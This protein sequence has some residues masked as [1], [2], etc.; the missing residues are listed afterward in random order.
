MSPEPPFAERARQRARQGDLPGAEAL[1]REGLRSDPAD[2]ELKG[3]LADVLD[4]QG[5][6]AEALTLVWEAPEMVR[7]RTALLARAGRSA[8]AAAALEEVLAQDPSAAWAHVQLGRLL[9]D[10]DRAAANA[11]FRKAVALDPE[12]LGARVALAYSLHSTRA[13][14]EGANLQAAAELVVPIVERLP[15][16][17]SA[18]AADILW[19]TGHYDAVQALGGFAELGRYWAQHGAPAAMLQQLPRVET[20]ADRLELLEQHRLWA[21]QAEAAAAR[22][23]IARPVRGGGEKLRLG[24]LSSDLRGH[25][26]AHFA[27]PL[28]QHRDPRFELFCYSA[29]PGPPD[30]A[31]KWIASRVTAYRRLPADDREAAELIA[32]DGLD[33]LVELGGLTEFSRPAVLAWRPALR[34]ASWLGYPHS[35]GLAAID[36]WICDPKLA[37]ERRELVA[38]QPLVLPETWVCLSPAAFHDDLPIAPAAPAARN[39]YVTFGTAGNTYKFNPR[40]LRAWAR[41]VAATPGSRFMIVRPEAGAP[42]FRENLAAH[43]AAEGV[44]AERLDFRP[45]RGTH[46]PLYNEIDVALDTFPLT[47]GTT[48]CEALWMGVPTVSLKG[49]APYERMGASLLQS[50]GLGDLVAED[51]G[52]FVQIATRLAADLPRLNE[53]RRGLRPR[54]RASALGQPERFAA[55]F[56]ALMARTIAERP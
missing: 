35:L 14:D 56:Y 20:D 17:A 51:E 46:R 24:F 1:A 4:A 42:V 23:P 33:M 40:L 11:H 22:R 45:V 38:E 7:R 39:G 49:E 41:T 25:I 8:E 47:G 30:R 6:S 43:F 26:V 48:T 54:I 36:G 50:A 31:A 53:L 13:G 9:Q 2:A 37:P 21:R 10:T 52:Q 34:Q 12:D 16:T 32:A 18:V 29:Y 5:R 3:L 44:A 15:K 19:R 28:F 27:H 55:D